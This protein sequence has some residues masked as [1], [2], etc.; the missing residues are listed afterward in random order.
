ME[1]RNSYEDARRAAAYDQ[2]EFGGTYHLAFRDLPALVKKHVTGGSA[3]DFGCGTGRSSRF[4]QQLGFV[5]VGLDVSAEMV[6]VA[7]DRDPEGDYRV[8][9]DGDFSSVPA[10]SCDLVQSAF[11]FDNI[12]GYERKARLFAGLRG[13]LG[14]QGR[15]V[16][17][18]ST[19]EIY[20]HEWM[21][22]TTEAFPENRRAKCGDVVKII[23][24]DYPDSR[25]VEDIIWPDPD[26]RE[27]YREAGL[28]VVEYLL[29]RATG[30]EDIAWVSETE[31]AP[32]AI[33]VLKPA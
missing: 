11:T 22:F 24:T 10:G 12:P 23:T 15:L 27:V 9:E 29:P 17:I 5:T 1:F 19:P 16:N 25:P 13:L 33:Y 32:W 3:V 2:L 7:R 14:P 20:W 6:A 28:E 30:D 21:T 4:L 26:Y 18:V 31:V 8:I